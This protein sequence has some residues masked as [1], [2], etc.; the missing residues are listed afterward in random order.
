MIDRLNTELIEITRL[1]G[2]V[3]GVSGSVIGGSN[4]G[5]SIFSSL[6]YKKASKI[7]LEYITS[8]EIHQLI[9]RPV[10]K[11]SNYD[12]YSVMYRK[13][14]YEYLFDDEGKSIT[15]VDVL[16][17]IENLYKIF[18]IKVHSDD[19][20]IG[21]IMV[22]VISVVSFTIIFSSLFYFVDRLIPYFDFLPFDFWLLTLFGAV[23]I[24]M[25]TLT[26]YG[27]ITG[28]KCQLRL[29]M[30][31]FGVTIN[32]VPTFQKLIV[33]FP[34]ENKLSEWV[35]HHKRLFV[36]PFI[37]VEFITNAIMLISP[38][39]VE[40]GTFVDIE[41]SRKNFS[42]CY[43]ENTF[44]RIML[45]LI[46]LLKFLV[47]IVICILIFVEWNVKETLYDVRFLTVCIY[48]DILMLIIYII[49]SVAE[50]NKSTEYTVYFILHSSIYL[51]VG[52]TN[53]IFLY[54][55]R[56][57]QGFMMKN[58]K[59]EFIKN[60]DQKFIDN[61][62]CISTTTRAFDQSID[63]KTTPTNSN[64]N[65]QTIANTSSNIGSD[66]GVI[67]RLISYHYRESNSV[68][69]E[70]KNNSSLMKTDK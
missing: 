48:V 65:G 69:S 21:L 61:E 20:N 63:C 13:Y 43:A 26:E 22:I 2:H 56:I 17:N 24:I 46:I 19:S 35:S 3:K 64:E 52:I 5:V 44:T 31:S 29:F 55:Y 41:N 39:S 30:L 60:I 58:R 50:L 51:V 42:V 68:F 16:N 9:S 10:N 37:M 66:S 53:Y 34:E 32:I 59:L 11:T 40:S 6:E 28:M 49:I 70:S 54:G 45:A 57:I 62:S 27:E 25:T 8:K 4:I 38:Y 47:L 15:A 18:Q 12:Y 1:P 33:N 36:L 23:L 7:V 67:K 14:F